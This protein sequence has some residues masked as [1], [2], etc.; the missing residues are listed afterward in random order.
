[1]TEPE[2][3][4]YEALL[5]SGALTQEEFEKQTAG[6]EP[7][8]AIARHFA[9]YTAVQAIF[10]ACICLLLHPNIALAIQHMRAD[11]PDRHFLQVAQAFRTYAVPGGCVLALLLSLI[12]VRLLKRKNIPHAKICT[13]LSFLISAAVTVVWLWM[14]YKVREII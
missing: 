3:R 9:A 1:M 8:E 11:N 2:Y 14:N 13:A 12:A 4:E 5:Q 10:A 6:Y 7:P